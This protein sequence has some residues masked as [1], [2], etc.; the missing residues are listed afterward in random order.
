MIFRPGGIGKFYVGLSVT[1]TQEHITARYSPI[2][3]QL[4]T[5]FV[6]TVL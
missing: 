6:R 5:P 3:R 2:I 1:I 4:D